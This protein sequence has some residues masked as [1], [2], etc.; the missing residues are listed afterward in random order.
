MQ[1]RLLGI[2]N[3]AG[4]GILVFVQKIR[5]DVLILGGAL[6]VGVLPP[7]IRLVRYAGLPTGGVAQAKVGL[8]TTQTSSASV[9]VTGDANADNAAAATALAFTSTGFVSQV[10][11]PR[12]VQATATAANSAVYEPVDTVDFLSVDTELVLQPGQG[13]GILLDA[14]TVTTGNPATNRWTTVIDWDEATRP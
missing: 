5:V 4:S 12:L 1:Q 7:V 3:A 13:C 9:T 11:A 2:N 6:A 10:W 14:A 8:D